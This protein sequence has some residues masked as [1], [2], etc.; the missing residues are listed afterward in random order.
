MELHTGI[1]GLQQQVVTAEV[2]ADKVGSGTVKVFATPMMIGM[3]EKAC[4]DSVQPYLEEGKGTVGTHVNV[5]HLAATP[6]GM[7]VTAECELIEIDGRRLVFKVS[8]RDERGLIGEGTHE[9]FI[10]DTVKFLAKTNNK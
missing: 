10:I 7:K 1:S 3:I 9:R 2:T 6:V 8:A 4:F 5:S